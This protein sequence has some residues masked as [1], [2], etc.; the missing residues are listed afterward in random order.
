[1]F[2]RSITRSGSFHL[3]KTLEQRRLRGLP[4]R[5]LLH[6]DCFFRR[7]LAWLELSLSPVARSYW[8][9]NRF[10]IGPHGIV[11]ERRFT[12]GRPPFFLR[13]QLWPD[14]WHLCENP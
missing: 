10:S 9:L 8:S 4:P 6:W 5:C 7:S 11:K 2:S 1:M 12:S 13:L 3:F 14:D